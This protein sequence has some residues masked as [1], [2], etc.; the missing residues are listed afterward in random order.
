MKRT[1]R[2]LLW[3]AAIVAACG[4]LLA[5]TSLGMAHAASLGLSS[6]GVVTNNRT[7]G[8]PLTCTLTAASDTYIRSDQVNNSFGS[9]TNLDVNAQGSAI[10][11]LFVRFDLTACSPQIASDAIVHSATVRL[12]TSSLAS[13][14]TRTYDLFRATSSWTETTTWT[15]QPTVAGSAT[16]SVTVP[17]LT[18]TG[19]TFQWSAGRDVQSFIAADQTNLGWRLNDA[20]EGGLISLATSFSS[21]EAA[22]NRPQLD[23]SYSP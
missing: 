18:I 2:A 9:A 10:R 1:S 13:T 22:S 16:S 4:C 12:T 8:S 6:T 20:N 11:R 23:I 17:A 19:T 14:S 7:Y 3:A 21:R 15:T 5:V